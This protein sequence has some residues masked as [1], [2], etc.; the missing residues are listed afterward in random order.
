MPKELRAALFANRVSAIPHF[1]EEETEL[2]REE[3]RCREGHAE[4]RWPR[5][6]WN[7]DLQGSVRCNTLCVQDRRSHPGRQSEGCGALCVPLQVGRA[8]RGRD[9]RGGL[10][11]GECAPPSPPQHGHSGNRSGGNCE[12][13]VWLLNLSYS[14]H[15]G[16]K[17]VSPGVQK[18]TEYL[19]HN[20]LE[21]TLDSIVSHLKHYSPVKTSTDPK[22]SN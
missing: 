8:R 9:G 6:D 4:N 16:D 7:L 14:D 2:P 18:A 3:M 1:M 17:P 10:P 12:G 21:N 5:L 22:R 15:G 19:W 13:Q 20:F 11:A